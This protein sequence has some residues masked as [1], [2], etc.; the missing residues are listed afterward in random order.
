[1]WKCWAPVTDSHFLHRKSFD[2][3]NIH[4]FT[5]S[6]YSLPSAQTNYS[7]VLKA[8]F[9]LAIFR[10]QSILLLCSP[11]L[12]LLLF[13]G[14]CNPSH[15]IFHIECTHDHGDNE[16]S[17]CTSHNIK[18]LFRILLMLRYSNDNKQHS[19]SKACFE[20]GSEMEWIFFPFF[21][22]R[23]L[24]VFSVRLAPT[25]FNLPHYNKGTYLELLEIWI[26]PH[27]GIIWITFPFFLPPHLSLFLSL[28][29]ACITGKLHQED[30][31]YFERPPSKWYE[32]N[33]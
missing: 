28:S 8:F 6:V 11:L 9:L 31:I 18:R 10:L 22:I 29:I 24:L 2:I 7:C 4:L 25:P 17:T 12:L 16:N 23:T 20:K 32:C 33:R 1:M 14:V 15:C 21:C 5:H 26:H 13:F 3:I 27:Y 30:T 19:E